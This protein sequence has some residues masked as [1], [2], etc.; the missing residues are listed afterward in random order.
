MQ[1]FHQFFIS[2]LVFFLLSFF[3]IGFLF[4]R[5]IYDCRHRLRKIVAV[6]ETGNAV[7][8]DGSC[9]NALFLYP[10]SSN[11]YHNDVLISGHGV[12]GKA[13]ISPKRALPYI[14]NIFTNYTKIATVEYLVNIC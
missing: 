1:E 3:S 13:L 4:W 5:I 9:D 12:V 7:L 6:T 10:L 14:K 8:L 11:S 2:F